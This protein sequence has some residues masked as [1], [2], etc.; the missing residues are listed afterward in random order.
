VAEGAEVQHGAERLRG[1]RCNPVE[2]LIGLSRDLQRLTT[3]GELEE[4]KASL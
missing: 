1:S 3:F 2:D 4:L